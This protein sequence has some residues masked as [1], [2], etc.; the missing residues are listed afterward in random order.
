MS[1]QNIR[2]AKRLAVAWDDQ[3]W[4]STES[5]YW[6][7]AELMP[8]EAWPE[9]G[10]VKGWSAIQQQFE[11]LKDAWAEDHWKFDSTEAVSEDVV[12]QH[13]R[14]RGRGKGSGLPFDFEAWIIYRFRAG[15]ITRIE[16]YLDRGQAMDAAGG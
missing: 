3:D 16:Y 7:D 1:E 14:W 8:P 2:I 11:R 5:L 10:E 6:P 9:A 13:G 15:K 4:E 12:L